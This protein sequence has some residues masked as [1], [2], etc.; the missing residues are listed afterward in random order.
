MINRKF[1]L[2]LIF[3]LGIIFESYFLNHHAFAL[4]AGAICGDGYGPAD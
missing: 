4:C 1:C 2:L 3:L